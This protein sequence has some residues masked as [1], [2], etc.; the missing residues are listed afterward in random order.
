M[1]FHLLQDG[2]MFC[3]IEETNVDPS[4]YGKPTRY[5]AE[6][7]LAKL[8]LNWAVYTAADVATYTPTMSNEK[9]NAV[10]AMWCSYQR[11]YL[12]YAI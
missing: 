7:L 4:T 2:K 9:L 11:L 12:C 5:M 3:R 8:Y 10:V 6:A 1:H